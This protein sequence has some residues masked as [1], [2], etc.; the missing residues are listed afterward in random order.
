MPRSAMATLL[1]EAEVA[2]ELAT[3]AGWQREGGEIVR[4]F[5]FPDYMA[6]IEFV[7][8]VA[9]SAEAANH[10]PDIQIG[11]RKVTLRLSTH[12]QG[13]LTAQD[14]AMAREIDRLL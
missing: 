5:Q 10:H 13:G 3:I 11:W 9:R 2:R 1:P 6:G 14:F 12:S 4:R 8:R 7:N